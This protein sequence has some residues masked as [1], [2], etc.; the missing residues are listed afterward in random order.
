MTKND[1]TYVTWKHLITLL[2]TCVIGIIMIIITTGQIHASRPHVG[3]ATRNEFIELK[4]IIK[5]NK[6]ELDNDL[7]RNRIEILKRLDDLNNRITHI[8]DLY[9]DKFSKK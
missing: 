3:S 4:Q 6:K 5:D 7:Q 1:S 9:A 8:Y 2:A